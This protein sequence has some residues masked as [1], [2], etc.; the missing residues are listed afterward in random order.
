MVKL[1][2]IDEN[3]VV[4]GSGEKVAPYLRMY[5][6]L[7]HHLCSYLE[8]QEETQFLGARQKNLI[9]NYMIVHVFEAEVDSLVGIVDYFSDSMLGL[10]CASPSDFTVEKL[11]TI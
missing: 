5:S 3:D 9:K 4:Q 10:V 6:S 7:T 8:N 11:M 2:I 1:N